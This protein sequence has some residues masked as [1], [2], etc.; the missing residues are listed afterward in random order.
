MTGT[1]RDLMRGELNRHAPELYTRF[2]LHPDGRAEVEASGEE[3]EFP[4]I[5]PAFVGRRNRFVYTLGVAS[6]GPGAWGLRRVV[7]RDV[8]RW[9]SEA[10]DH[11]PG[12]I[13]E[14]H[15]FVPRRNHRSEDDG[16]VVGTF[17]DYTRKLQR[18][19]SVR[20]RTHRRRPARSGLARLSSPARLPRGVLISV[21]P[22]P[23]V[24]E[25]WWRARGKSGPMS[26]GRVTLSTHAP[27]RPPQ[28]PQS[29][30]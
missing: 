27:S 28:R 8:E 19:R 26:D 12:V 5:A 18:H 15:V 21:R 10:F 29:V 22:E 1:M 7:K 25:T 9:T 16:W 30:A 4:R 11:G 17:L 13:A 20:C 2:A 23:K 14:E 6:T 3:A 24:V